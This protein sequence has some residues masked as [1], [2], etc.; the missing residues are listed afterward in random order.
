MAYFER[1]TST[2][3]GGGRFR[4]TPHTGGGWNPAEQHIAPTVGLVAHSL[5][6][7]SAGAPVQRLAVEILGTIGIDEVEVQVATVRPGRTI[8]L[9]EATVAWAGRD[10]VRARAWR[11]A[12]SDTTEVAASAEPALPAREEL[13]PWDMSTA[14]PGGYIAS[15]EVR[16]RDA[17]PGRAQAWLRAR[18]ELLDD[19]EVTDLTRTLL[20]ADTANGLVQGPGRRGWFYPNVELTVHLFR[21]PVGAWVGMD[22]SVSWGPGGHGLTATVL[23]DEA[24]PVGRVSQSCTLRRGP[25]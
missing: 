11:L 2:P 10:V 3:D 17:G 4:A 21:A 12:G 22:T 15:L 14:W 7:A 20:L 25:G 16:H 24:G 6:R 8:E 23:H 1:L 18:Q 5:Q 9:V 19:E 13:A